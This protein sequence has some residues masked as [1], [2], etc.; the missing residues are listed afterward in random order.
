MFYEV[1]PLRGSFYFTIKWRKG[2]IIG[3]IFFL[4]RDEALQFLGQKLRVANLVLQKFDERSEEKV[5]IALNNIQA[6]GS[7]QT[8]YISRYL[9]L[10]W[11]RKKDFL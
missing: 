2:L 3:V 7:Q 1:K 11:K 9:Q 10:I 6:H 5:K 4:R 8:I